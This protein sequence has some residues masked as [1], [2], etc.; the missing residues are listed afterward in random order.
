MRDCQTY[1]IHYLS[2]P[3]PFPTFQF[4]FPKF[5]AFCS[6]KGTLR[7]TSDTTTH[8]TQRSIAFIKA[9]YLYTTRNHTQSPRHPNP[10]YFK[11]MLLFPL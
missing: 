10:G 4:S 1:G 3:Y 8:A 7:S 5:H 2:A 9:A 6:Q 11:Q